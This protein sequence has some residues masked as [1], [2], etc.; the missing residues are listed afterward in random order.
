MKTLR[1]LSV[2]LSFSVSVAIPAM[3][4]VTVNSPAK[5]DQVS[6]PFKLSAWATSCGSQSVAAMGYSY[7]SSSDTTVIAGQAIDKSISGPSGNHML[8]VKAWGKG[9]AC[10][11]DIAIDVRSGNSSGAESSIVPSEAALVTH[12]DAMSGWHAHHDLGGPGSSSGL[13]KM[14]SSPS[15]SGS[16]REFE[17]AFS[18][19]GDERYSLSFSDDTSARNFFYDAWFYVTSSSENIANLEFDINQAMSD[20]NT[21]MFGIICDGYTG[22]WAYTANTGSGSH[23]SPRHITKNGTSCNPRAWSQNKWHHVQAYYSHDGS[24]YITYHAVW[25][26]GTEAKIDETVLGKYDLGWDSIINTQFQVDGLG[27]SHATV[28]LANLNISRW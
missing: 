7:D 10:V 20:G 28:Y 15:L 12:L 21:V 9:T 5:S 17:T 19:S 25:L 3:A 1:V 8:H 14:V 27:S 4:G 18:N 13:M 6:S 11:A 23:P 22:H 16:A 24:G 2:V 26:D